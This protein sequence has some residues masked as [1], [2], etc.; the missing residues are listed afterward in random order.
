MLLFNCN[1]QIYLSYIFGDG[2]NKVNKNILMLSVLFM[3]FVGF[4]LAEPAAAVK[5]ADQGTKYA[6]NGQ[7]GHIKLVWKTY[8]YNN[9]FLKTYVAKY[10][11]N[12]KTKKYEYGDDEEFIFAKVTKNSVKITNVA[13]LLSDFS[14]DPVE[15]TY[16]KTKLT[17][18]QYYWRVFRPQTL[19]KANI[20]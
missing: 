20:M 19:M 2:G 14:S 9:N 5:V 6:W 10:L 16:K 7:D 15:I 13:E 18:A 11:K 1:L 17:G 4:Q 8:Q 3:F 12:E